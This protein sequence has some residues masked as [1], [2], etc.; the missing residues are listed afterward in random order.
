MTGGRG[1]LVGVF[2]GYNIRPPLVL[3]AH[4][5]DFGVALAGDV[6]AVAVGF[7]GRF[8]PLDASFAVAKS[9]RIR[10]RGV[11][12]NREW[13]TWVQGFRNRLNIER[14]RCRH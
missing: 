6:V 7:H 11:R 8:A 12:Q 9:K 14:S 10:S 4:L 13:K 1:A 5:P 3:R 2:V